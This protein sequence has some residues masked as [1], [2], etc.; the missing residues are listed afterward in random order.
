MGNYTQA[1]TKTCFSKSYQG[2]TNLAVEDKCGILFGM[3]HKMDE[4]YV[5]SMPNERL[6]YF[7]QN[8]TISLTNMVY[9]INM[10]TSNK[11]EEQKHG[12]NKYQLS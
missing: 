2:L 12:N 5:L 11:C 4:E 1:H 6:D 9:G 10:G 8:Q 3:D 7:K